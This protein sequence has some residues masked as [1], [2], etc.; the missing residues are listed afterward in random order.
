MKRLRL[1]QRDTSKREAK[2]IISIF[3]DGNKNNS[4]PLKVV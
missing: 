2:K 3:F 4:V 1:Y